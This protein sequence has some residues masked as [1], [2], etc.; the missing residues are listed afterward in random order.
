M[1]VAHVN[2][3]EN[4]K[5][6]LMRLKGTVVLYDGQPHYIGA[7][8]NHKTDGIFRVY[9]TPTGWDKYDHRFDEYPSE[10]PSQ[11]PYLD[12]IVDHEDPRS[13][14][15]M[16]RKMMNSPLFNKFRPFPLGMVNVGSKTYYTERQP[17]RRTEQGLTRTMLDVTPVT[18]GASATY[19]PG[20]LGSGRKTELD[21]HSP[22][23]KACILGDHP[24]ADTCL[25]ELLSGE[26]ENEAV[27]FHRQFAFVKGPIGMLF[28]AY[29]TDII[30]ILPKN[31]FS[32]IR[33]GG[34]F[35]HT[36]EAVRDLRLF[37]EVAI[38]N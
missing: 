12:A 16:I 14:K 10:H 34:Q 20:S 28:L 1:T 9:M 7:I 25:N 22:A 3:Y 27:A 13:N 5:E 24:S 37:S 30:G 2:F 32:V 8:C 33:V 23:Y 35:A 21:V 15:G 17:Q 26:V 38:Q 31:D 6:A 11:G 19:L 36:I 18:L 4:I 29:K